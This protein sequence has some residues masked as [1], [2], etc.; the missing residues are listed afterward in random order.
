MQ[1]ASALAGTEPREDEPALAQLGPLDKMLSQ[2][3]LA[4]GR[5]TRP[6]LVRA[7]ALAARSHQPFRLLLDR[8]GLISLT[9]WAAA[10]AQATGLDLIEADALPK[11]LPTDPRLS[12]AFMRRRAVLPLELNE[13]RARFVTP[14]PLDPQTL[15]A[16]RLMFA[17]R[18]ELAVASDRDIEAAFAR[19]DT[20]EDEDGE[21]ALGLAEGAGAENDLERLIELA[22]NAP[23]IRFVEELFGDALARRATDIHLEP[24]SERPRVRFRVDGILVEGAA[25]PAGLYRG[26]VSRLKIL[27][28]LDVAERRQPQDGRITFK[29]DNRRIDIRIAIAPTIHGEA[30]TLRF[31]DARA[32]LAELRSLD[33]PS[34]VAETLSAALAMPNGLILVTGPT[35][36][37]K[38]TTLHAAL[39][40]LNEIGR[41]IVT[42]ENPVEI[43]TPGLIQIEVDAGLDWT[44][45]AAL[46]AILRHDPDVLMVGEIRDEET[47]EMAVRLALTG[48]LV[49][50]TVHTNSASE[51]PT[52]LSNLGVAEH[53]MAST[54]RMVASQRLVRSL[55][56]DCAAPAEPEAEALFHRMVALAEE[57]NPHWR[58][59]QQVQLRRPKGCPSCN[60]QGFRGRIGVF[61][62]FGADVA[63]ASLSSSFERRHRSMGEH[64]L[65]RVAA[66]ETTLDEVLRIVGPPGAWS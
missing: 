31:L 47:A 1:D 46:R 14:D 48:H 12:D 11:R 66:G 60:E 44:F 38:T 21:T 33:M 56:P 51:G 5:L 9:D 22:N 28:N 35:G 26:I 23:T 16:L 13:S 3:F 32:G 20:A 30:V 36:S 27:S 29:A 17:D 37:G 52:R 10:A 40:E 65:E 24:L 6:D 57:A 19:A 8:L 43:M 41:K 63:L 25:P 4:E 15:S 7:A 50:S 61:E 45:A 34:D 58:A 2:T 62:A 54:L 59:P 42:I 18:L 53:L 39:A 49:F 64:G 55:C